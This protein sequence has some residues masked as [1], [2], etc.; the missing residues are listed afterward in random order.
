MNMSEN[1]VKTIYKLSELENKVVSRLRKQLENY[2]WGI[3]F[4]SYFELIHKHTHSN[5]LLLDRKT[6]TLTHPYAP[7]LFPVPAMIQNDIVQSDRAI[8][9]IQVSQERLDRLG[10]FFVWCYKTIRR[11]QWMQSWWPLY[12]EACPGMIGMDQSDYSNFQ[13]RISQ[14]RLIWLSWF[15]VCRCKTITG[16]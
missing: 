9:Q 4:L 16:R 12:P 2:I 3:F 15:F 8:L 11:S 13:I 1:W 5:Q 6:N 14:E 7:I 10:W